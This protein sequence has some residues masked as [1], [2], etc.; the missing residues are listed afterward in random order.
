MN[1]KLALIIEDDENL[2]LIYSESLRQ[3]GYAVEVHPR[4]DTAIQR[5]EEVQPFLVLVDL[6]LPRMP[7]EAILYFI[8]S[9]EA[10]KEIHV[11][12]VGDDLSHASSMQADADL[13]LVKPVSFGELKEQAEKFLVATL[14]IK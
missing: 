3:A 12:A 10:L 7:G 1:T 11:I 13:L 8:R 2:A 5:M 4:G 9:H 6:N 14:S